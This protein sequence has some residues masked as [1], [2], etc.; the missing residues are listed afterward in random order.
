MTVAFACW[1]SALRGSWR[2]VTAL[3]LLIGILGAVALG[4]LAGARR[5]ASAYGRYLASINVS[6]VFVNVPG[7]VPGVPVARPIQ[8]ISRLGGISASSAYLGLDADPVVH[9]RVDDAFQTNNMTGSFSAP[10]IAA[11][12]LQQDRVSVLAGRV[13]DAS[14]TDQIAITP[15]LARLF[16]VGV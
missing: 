7:I 14:S 5:T 12:F 1:R 9:G 4:A 6:D 15:G 10:H 3:T 8:L 11:G 13:P 16:G 2:Q